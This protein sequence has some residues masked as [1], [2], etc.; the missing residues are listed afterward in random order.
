MID[1][2]SKHTSSQRRMTSEDTT[3]VQIWKDNITRPICFW[4]VICHKNIIDVL[5]LSVCKED[6]HVLAVLTCQG[7][8]SL[9][10]SFDDL[11]QC[12]IFTELQNPIIE[13]NNGGE[14]ICVA[15]YSSPHSSSSVS[16]HNWLHFYN[17]RGFIRYRIPVPYVMVRA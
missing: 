6:R 1:C 13:W 16:Y 4:N 7:K 17:D 3:K 12:T 11:N 5:F 15:G 2:L 8:L 9:M 14:F 10:K